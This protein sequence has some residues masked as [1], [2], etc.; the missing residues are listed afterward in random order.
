M[1]NSISHTFIKLPL[2]E[3]AWVGR[4]EEI[5]GIRLQGVVA[6]DVAVDAAE[7]VALFRDY[8]QQHPALVEKAKR[9][10]SGFNLGCTCPLG[11]RSHA[12]L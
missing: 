11:Q 9:E 1:V 12:D 4:A 10:L 7:A 5:W 3:S 8:V 2:G 6:T